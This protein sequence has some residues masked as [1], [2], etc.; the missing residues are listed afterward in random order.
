M[1]PNSNESK[2]LAR[3]AKIK[4][5]GQSTP[6]IWKNYSQKT[7][8]VELEVYFSKYADRRYIRNPSTKSAM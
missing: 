2:F 4:R 3:Q 5:L 7:G 1:S 8:V 6:N